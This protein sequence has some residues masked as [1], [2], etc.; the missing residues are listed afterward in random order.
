MSLVAS[1]TLPFQ[2]A[3]ETLQRHL[4]KMI[5]G[6]HVDPVRPRNPHG[7]C[8]LVG[9][10]FQSLVVNVGA[11]GNPESA[12]STRIIQHQHKRYL[13]I[14][15]IPIT[16]VWRA[17][18]TGHVFVTDIKL[19]GGFELEANFAVL[20]FSVVR[21]KVKQGCVPPIFALRCPHQHMSS[22]KHFSFEKIQAHFL[23]SRVRRF[24]GPLEP[25]LDIVIARG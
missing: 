19:V 12:M 23:K 2:I 17:N 13:L 20:D 21:R 9:V 7:D 4:A 16:Q 24:R 6:S 15:P 1:R 14:F 10:Y 18:A 25:A 5:D 22:L 8:L 3:S 11:N